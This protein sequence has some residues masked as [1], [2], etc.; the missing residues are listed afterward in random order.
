MLPL[1]KFYFSRCFTFA[2]PL[3][4]RVARYGRVCLTVLA[5]FNDDGLNCLGRYSSLV[6]FV[7]GPIEGFDKIDTG[8]GGAVHSL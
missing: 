5:F 6:R 1:Y 2:E 8:M 4:Q 7:H 3:P